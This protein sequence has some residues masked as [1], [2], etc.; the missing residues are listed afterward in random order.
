MTI[1]S[2]CDIWASLA[3]LVGVGCS[4]MGNLAPGAGRLTGGH[5]IR[6]RGSPGT[7]STAVLK[8]K[9]VRH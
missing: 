6:P 3:P 7:L 9:L 2:F 1:R 8:T 4:A 5:H